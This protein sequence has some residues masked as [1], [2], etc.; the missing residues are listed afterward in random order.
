MFSYYL[1][2]P[3][4]LSW[5]SF[6]TTSWDSIY[7]VFD[8]CSLF[9]YFLCVFSLLSC[10]SLSHAWVGLASAE[11][12]PNESVDINLPS[13][14]FPPSFL[15]HNSCPFSFS[16]FPS[17]AA[18]CEQLTRYR[19]DCFVSRSY[20]AKFHRDRQ[21]A[22]RCNGSRVVC[23][24][25]TSGIPFSLGSTKYYCHLLHN[26]ISIGNRRAGRRKSI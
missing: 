25:F 22:D 18:V 19:V 6:L 26:S 10:D 9:V 8:P 15:D 4:G 17:T 20:R 3:S 7:S 1:A 14:S 11:L 5:L 16:S 2:I 13:H 21:F 12:G 23:P 24:Y